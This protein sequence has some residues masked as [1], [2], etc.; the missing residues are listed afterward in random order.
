MD[1]KKSKW[2]GNTGNF[3]HKIKLIE[4]YKYEKIIQKVEK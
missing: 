1:I 2:S 4:K 3:D